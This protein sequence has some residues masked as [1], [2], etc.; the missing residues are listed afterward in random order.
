M[1]VL[2]VC[3]AVLHSAWLLPVLVAL[4]AI[5]APFP[6]LPSETLLMSAAAMA[7]GG[8]DAGMVVGLFLAAVLGSALGD[9]VVFG[10]GRSSRRLLA[11]AVDAECGLSSWVRR[12][13]LLRPGIALVGARFVPG[14]RLVSTAAAGRYGLGLRRFLP[15]SLASSAAWAVYMLLIG[16]LLGPI[17]G[18]SPAL[19]LLAGAVMAAVTALGFAVARRVQARRAALAAQRADRGAE[20]V[21]VG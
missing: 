17:T 20:L 18:G 13:L 16:M 19:S 6:V 11:R 12:H 9:L 21:G 14:G 10:L 1:D 4:V 5:D 15:W 2:A 3:D 7:F 8:H